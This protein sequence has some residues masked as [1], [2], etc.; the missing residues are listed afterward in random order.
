MFAA[1]A[2]G[3]VL[4]GLTLLAAIGMGGWFRAPTARA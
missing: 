3:L 1:L 2:L 4:H